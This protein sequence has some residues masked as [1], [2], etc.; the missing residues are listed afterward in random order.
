M[1]WFEAP[2]VEEV[3]A[4]YKKLSAVR[5]SIVLARRELQ[6]RDDELKAEYPR[7]PEL[8]RQQTESLYDKLAQ[9]EVA[10]IEAQQEVEFMNVRLKM[11]QTYMYRKM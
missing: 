7:K 9:L 6:K 5:G 2:E 10:E 8:R 3:D 4:V 1:E 11:F